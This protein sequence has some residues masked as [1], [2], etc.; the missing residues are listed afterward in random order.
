VTTLLEQVVPN[1]NVGSIERWASLLT[2]GMLVV[3]GVKCPDAVGQALGVGL[4]AA[5]IVRG[6]TGYCPLYAAGGVDTAHEPGPA[7]AVR[8]GHGFK[9]EESITIDRPAAE[10]Y[11]FWRNF[12]QL[13]RFMNHLKKVTWAGGSRSHWIAE[14]PMGVNAEWD[15]EVINDRPNE[16]IAWKSVEGS[17]VDTAGSVHFV[18][19]N[20]GHS[21]EVR[22]SLKYG[23]PG[24]KSGARLAWLAAY[25]AETL[26]R[27]DLERFRQLME[28]SYVAPAR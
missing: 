1:A 14:G 3:G 20:N 8:A 10:L 7:T 2:G 4:G 27:E 24:G 26:V 28:T 16:L 6:A 19:T 11:S 9:F 23:P 12:E 21:T 13:P 22:V 18:P 17:R 5:L 25:Y 15:A